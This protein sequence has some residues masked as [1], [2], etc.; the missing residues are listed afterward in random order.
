MSSNTY[1]QERGRAIYIEAMLGAFLLCG[2]GFALQWSYG[3]NWADEGLLWYGSQRTALGDVPIRDFFS[4]DPGRYYWNSVFFRIFDDAGLF[5]LLLAGAAFGAVGLAIIWVAV[6][7]AGLNWKLRV[8]C[9]I[10][11][12][13]ALG[14]PRHKVYEQSL[15][16]ILVAIIFFV[17]SDPGRAARWFA[18]GIFAGLAAFVGRNHG[19][20]F[21]F[22]AVVCATYVLFLR[23]YKQRSALVSL[24]WPFAAGVVVGYLPMISLLLSEPGFWDAFVSSVLFTSNWQLPLPIPFVWRLNFGRPLSIEFAQQIAIGIACILIP[25]IYLYGLIISLRNTTR[26]QRRDPVLVLV[27]ASCTAGV[28]YLHQAFDR[29]DFGHIAQAT[30]PVFP[31]VFALGHY[32]WS[33]L[34]QKVRSGLIVGVSSVVLLAS[35]L[36]S[37]P[38]IRYSRMQSDHP[39]S[40]AAIFIAGKEFLVEKYQADL[41]VAVERAI[42][43]CDVGP[44]E[45]FAAPHFPGIY[46][47]LNAK[48]PFWEMYYLYPR[49]EKFQEKHIEAIGNTRLMLLAPEATVDGLERLKLTNTYPLLMEYINRHYEVLESDVL[50]SGARLY[51]PLGDCVARMG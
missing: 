7:R 1:G 48:A 46:A 36:P 14:F 17:L 25:V 45:F 2:L 41:L 34:G 26:L 21:V 11:I 3:F 51:V 33:V 29:A 19:V 20:F 39:D 43:V 18:F 30:L 35:W 15:S 31:A 10:L 24:A 42:D 12:L 23:P 4:Y 40:V 16:L 38:V 6:G 22:A 13:V 49:P 32:H 50:P 44:K 47:Y 28:A 37:E 5:T 9:G 27:A 8:A